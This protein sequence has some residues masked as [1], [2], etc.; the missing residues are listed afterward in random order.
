MSSRN[1]GERLLSSGTIT[2]EQLQIA[3]AEQRRSHRLLGELV[4]EL[5]FATPE[6][7]ARVVAEIADARYVS[8][9]GMELDRSLR[10]LVDEP[11][12]R[13]RRLVPLAVE[14]RLLTVAMV[15]PLDIV[16]VDQLREKSGLDIDIMASSE[17][18]VTNAQDALYGS[19]A[20]GASLEQLVE[21]ASKAVSISRDAGE[22]EL[23]PVIQLVGR[24][25][26]EA[27]RLRA[28]D[29]H[30]EPEEHVV[31]VRYRVDGIL[32]SGLSLT[33]D[34]KSSV[35]V[36]L[37]IL[38]GMDISESRLPQD[39]RIRITTGQRA[40]DLRVSTMPTVHGENV[41][42]RVLDKQNLV[43]GLDVLMSE[44]ELKY[45]RPMLATQSGMILVTG[46]TG[47]GKTTT[48]YS[49]ISSLDASRHKIATLE[50]PVEYELPLIR[51]SQIHEKAGFG[52]VEG[53]RALLRQDPDIVFVGEMR[54]PETASIAVRAAL[55][56]HLVLS[57]LH[58]TSAL[59]TL[60]RLT[61]MG[62]PTDLLM[63]SLRGIL[64]QRLVR[65][66]CQACEAPSN[67]DPVLL[68]R[69]GI[70]PEDAPGLKQGSGCRVCFDT[71]YRGRTGLYELVRVTPRLA[72]ALAMGRSLTELARIAAAD[73]TRFLRQHGLDKARAGLTTLE[74]VLK[75][76]A[77]APIPVQQPIAE[78]PVHA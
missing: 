73:G 75:A 54:D 53:L 65:L 57:T 2:S 12:A 15:N 14:G 17:P 76:T 23:G 32:R 3:L 55:T 33:N 74:E 63:T 39:G 56:G 45:L 30:V 66:N 68:R 22:R 26:S 70:A 78:A 61:Q 13:K 51:Q 20:R 11:F 47:A 21:E 1:F 43:R 9:A 10:E 49:A 77:D 62:I 44:R 16:A 29:I 34:L 38:A 4:S 71:G 36:R 7:V 24:L 59:G 50:D 60:T 18:E 25:L 64:A 37:K 46:P 42:L 58:T 8:L 69:L 40:Y 5:G 48:L 31:R 52:F 41:V 19:E 27:V 72:D 67:P 28:T 6:Q 35:T